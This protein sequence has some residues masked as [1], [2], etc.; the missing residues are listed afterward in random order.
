MYTFTFDINMEKFT[1]KINTLTPTII[2]MVSTMI[3]HVY[4][5]DKMLTLKDFM[6]MLS[7]TIPTVFPIIITIILSIITAFANNL[8]IPTVDFSFFKKLKQKQIQ[9]QHKQLSS[10]SPP[11]CSY[12]DVDV[13][14]TFMQLLISHIYNKKNGCMYNFDTG[15]M[16]FKTENVNIVETQT[17]RNINIPKNNITLNIDDLTITYTI[18]ND[19]IVLTD[20]QKAL[21]NMPKDESECR[22]YTRFVDFLPDCNFKKEFTAYADDCILKHGKEC[23]PTELTFDNKIFDIIKSI[24]PKMNKIAFL[25]ELFIFDYWSRASVGAYASTSLISFCKTSKKVIFF[26]YEFEKVCE[27]SGVSYSEYF[28]TIGNFINATAKKYNE[29]FKDSVVHTTA[30]A[31]KL[32]K[33]EEASKTVDKQIRFSTNINNNPRKFIDNVKSF[34]KELQHEEQKFKPGKKVKIFNVKID[35]KEEIII[36]ENPEYAIYLERKELFLKAKEKEDKK[37]DKKETISD[38][39]EFKSHHW[40]PMFMHPPQKEIKQTKIV[41]IL[42]S[43]QINE[44]YKAMH[45]LYLRESDIRSLTNILTNFKNNT[46]LFNEYGLPNKLGILLY[47]DPGTGKTSTIHAIASFLQKNIYYVNLGTVKTNEELQMIFDYITVQSTGGG[48]IVFEDVDV[49]SKVVHDRKTVNM[50][51]D[52]LTL[53]YFL[54]LLQGSLTRDGTIFVATTNDLEKLDPAFYRIGRFDIKI[55]MKK[56]DRYQIKTVFKKFVGRE[57]EDDIVNKIPENTYSPAEIIFHVVHHI[58]DSL[59]SFEIMKKFMTL[60]VASSNLLHESESSSSNLLHESEPS[61]SNLL[62]KSNEQTIVV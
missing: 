40:D 46:D 41:P 49:M 12:V 59:S 13:D 16:K 45:T 19:D 11:T 44:K 37:E 47:G 57:L 23:N 29:I 1:E 10:S 4:K 2:L 22:E 61:S 5:E 27:L 33:K 30:F 17:W 8:R 26:E 9:H 60:D 32:K 6:I 15:D 58:N 36:T 31:N 51:N 56:C 25:T 62:H 3:N 21:E 54:N 34:I 38:Y 39:Y 20:F 43:K 55:H 50:E 35:R 52:G 42:D 18:K 48:I 7:P 24:C 28:Y 14:I 53:E